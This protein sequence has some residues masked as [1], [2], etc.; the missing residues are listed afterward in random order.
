MS[1]WSRFVNVFRRRRVT[2]EI[3]AELASHL[4]EAVARGRDPHE[5]R[6]AFGS[7]LRHRGVEPR[8]SRAGVARGHPRRCGLQRATTVR[9]AGHDGR[10]HS[11]ARARH[12]RLLVGLPSHRRPA[13]SAAAR[14]RA[15]ATLRA[16]LRRRR[17]RWSVDRPRWLV[18]S[19][20]STDARGGRQARR[21][22]S[23]SSRPIARE[24]TYASEHEMERAYRSYVSGWMFE[25]FGLRPALG[26]LFTEDDDRTPGAH[27]YA[28]LSHDYWT[29]RFG[30]P[31]RDRRTFACASL[32]EIVGVVDAGFTGT[33]PARSPTCSSRR[34]R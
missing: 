31:G 28:V 15:R 27:P 25:S 5:A 22:C 13:A 26:R 32:Y 29:R 11:V 18:L 6:R 10:G 16:D 19:H 30:P 8:H 21:R 7:P 23:R 3:D 4:E 14:H 33:E 34:W 12:W 24:L 9:A 1:Q 20:V 2:R 17:S